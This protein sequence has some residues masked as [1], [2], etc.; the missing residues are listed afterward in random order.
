MQIEAKTFKKIYDPSTGEDNQWYINDHCF[1]QDDSGLWHMFGITHEEPLNPLDEKFFAHATSAD[2]FTG[3]WKK[4]EH[5]L[6]AEYDDW[7]EMHVWAPY[8]VKHDDLFHMFYCGGDMEHETYKIH[9]ATSDDL[10]QWKRHPENPMVVDGF[11]ARDPMVIRHDGQWIM[12]YTATSE[13]AGGNHVVAAVTSRDLIHWSDKTVVFVHP[14]E[15]T[16]GGPTESPFVVERNNKFHLFVCTNNPYNDSVVYESDS[17]FQW[18]IQNQVGNFPAHAAEVLR[19][20]DEQWYISRCG[21][22]EGG[23]YLAEMEWIE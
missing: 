15:G 23:L 17:P 14:K 10:W 2:P 20:S 12:Y 5:V 22:G 8:I 11:D 21:W 3:E 7:G 16:F 19:I 13:P 1:V 18:N 6:H 4:Q 9:L